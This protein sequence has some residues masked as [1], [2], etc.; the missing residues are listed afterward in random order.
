MGKEFWGSDPAKADKMKSRIPLG[1]FAGKV[2]NRYL[3]MILKKFHCCKF[4]LSVPEDVVNG[5]LFLLS[6]KSAM[7]NGIVL[8]ID[9]GYSS[10]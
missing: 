2:L 6:E 10:C 3:S 8:P 4:F 1:K 7:I 9:G 5:I